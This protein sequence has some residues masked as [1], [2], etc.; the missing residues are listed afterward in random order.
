M[1]VRHD[2]FWQQTIKTV[3]HVVLFSDTLYLVKILA[4]AYQRSRY[5]QLGHSFTLAP[6]FIGAKPRG[7]L[8]HRVR[9]RRRR[10]SILPL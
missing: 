2:V 10:E 7:Y 9:G 6:I 5:E 4:F 8:L 3:P 1:F